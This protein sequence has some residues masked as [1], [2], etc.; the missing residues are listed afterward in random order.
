MTENLP[1]LVPSLFS[2]S[3]SPEGGEH[4]AGPFLREPF[5]PCGSRLVMT[6]CL[7]AEDDVLA[8]KIFVPLS[9]TFSVL[10][11]T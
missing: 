6:G 7:I 3:I 10:S 2:F 9:A 5:I 4:K 11:M 8:Q 1:A